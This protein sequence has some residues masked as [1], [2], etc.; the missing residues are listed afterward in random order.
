[1][2]KLQTVLILLLVILAGI[3]YYANRAILTSAYDAVYWKDR[4]EHSQWQLPLSPRIIGDNGLYAL[5]G[6]Q[7][8]HGTDPTKYN[9]EIPPLGK[10]AIG[11]AVVL[12]NNG[13]WYG[14]VTSLLVWILF[15]LLARTVLKHTTLAVAATTW[16]ALDPLLTSQWTATMLDS[17]QLGVTPAVFSPA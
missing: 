11:A 2:K 16:L 17:L 1:M 9:A 3:L 15:F 7:L 13:S 4:F 6:Y 8:M 5:E 10:Y 12:F 14:V